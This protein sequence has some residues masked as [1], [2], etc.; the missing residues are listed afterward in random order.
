MYYWKS[1]KLK[2]FIVKF[3]IFIFSLQCVGSF[4]KEYPQ[5]RYY[6]ITVEE[7]NF[8]KSRKKFPYLKV[9]KFKI[10]NLYEGK[11]FIYKLSGV[12]YD[13]D[14]YSEFLV[15]PASNITELFQQ[16]IL[17]TEIGTLPP[18][19]FEN[20]KLY[21][22]SGQI[23]SLYGDF[24]DSNNPAAVMELDIYI[25]RTSDSGVIFKKNYK[26]I[27]KIPNTQADELVKGWNQAITNILL[28]LESD[29]KKVETL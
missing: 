7:Q 21:T 11:N 16:W 19:L 4:T 8:K 20:E 13:A 17:K 2:F 22:L 9:N 5:K 1:L 24:I 10:S 25:Q 6:L 3:L 23:L 28:E 18:T 26:Q 14:F 27:I 29:L 15:F 12:R